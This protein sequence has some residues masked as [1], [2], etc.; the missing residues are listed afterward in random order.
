MINTWAIL[1]EILSTILANFILSILVDCVFP[2][3]IEKPETLLLQTTKNTP[4][5]NWPNLE[6]KH[7]KTPIPPSGNDL[8]THRQAQQHLEI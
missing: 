6:V 1:K 7:D 4:G 8:G 2:C 3:S 5:E